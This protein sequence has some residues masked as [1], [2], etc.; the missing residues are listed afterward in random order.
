MCMKMWPA[1][2]CGSCCDRVNL[3]AVQ[4]LHPAFVGC[5]YVCSR[6]SWRP[7]RVAALQVRPLKPA[8]PRQLTKI[9]WPQADPQL[10]DD[11]TKVGARR[12]DAQTILAELVSGQWRE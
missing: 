1:S 4:Q 3:V 10:D 6:S 12:A 9:C 7:S 2:D 8:N 11:Q 5:C